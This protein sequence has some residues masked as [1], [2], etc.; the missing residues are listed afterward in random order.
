MFENLISALKQ[1]AEH[2]RRERELELKKKQSEAGQQLKLAKRMYNLGE[3]NFASKMFISKREAW[4]L[5]I[6]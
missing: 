6:S 3:Y 2:N 5:K 1:K 4:Q